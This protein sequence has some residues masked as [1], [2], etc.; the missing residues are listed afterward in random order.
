MENRAITVTDSNLLRPIEFEQTIARKMNDCW[1][2][3]QVRKETATTNRIRI[4]MSSVAVASLT[5]L[6]NDLPVVTCTNM[7]VGSSYSLLT[8][9]SNTQANFVTMG[10]TSPAMTALVVGRQYIIHT[11][12]GST[13]AQW[14]TAGA[15]GTP[16]INQIFTCIAASAGT[17]IAVATD[18]VSA[19]V[20]TGTGTASLTVKS[21]PTFSQRD[22]TLVNYQ[23]S[24]TL[25]NEL[26]S[27]ATT[28]LV[29][30]WSGLLADSICEQICNAEVARL[31]TY[32][33]SHSVTTGNA[34]VTRY[35]NLIA[36]VYKFVNARRPK[37]SWIANATTVSNFIGTTSTTLVAPSIALPFV[38]DNE[39]DYLYGKKIMTSPSVAAYSGS[40]SGGTTIPHW[41]LIDLSRAVIYETPLIV[42]IDTESGR[43]TNKTTIYANKRAVGTLLDNDALGY[44]TLHTS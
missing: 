18:F 25:T 12:T 42:S 26:F 7:I 11:V 23:S 6:D 21:T 8:V 19:A 37:L 9:G 32:I 33:G 15:L 43:G 44:L 16:A 14:N 34:G 41:L 5:R 24:I 20:V 36:L 1:Y 10:S 2:Y 30:Y 3:G 40:A 38:S 17:G 29:E 35:D 4:N 39:A 28:S 13:T 22:L 31:I 27:D